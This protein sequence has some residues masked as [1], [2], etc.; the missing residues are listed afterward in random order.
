MAKTSRLVKSIYRLILPVVILVVLAVVAASVFLVHTVSVP[1]Q[2]AYLV[3][4]EKYGQFSTRGARVTDES[5]AN[6]D[7]TKSRGWLLKGAE[8]LPA[9]VFLH[10]YGADRSHVLDLAVK[11]NEAT[12]FTVLMPDERGH[13]VN[14][15]SAQS[16]FGGCEADDALA[17]VEFLRSLKTETGANLIGQNIGFYGVEMGAMSALNAAAKDANVKA[18][19]LDS[20][21]LSSDDVLESAIEKRFPFA[22]SVT[23]KIANLTTPIYFYNGCYRRDAACDLA[24]SV[25][26]RQILLLAGSAAPEL[27]DS[28]QKLDRCF[29]GDTEVETKTDLNPSGYNLMTASLEQATA[30]DQRVIEFFKNALSPQE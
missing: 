29:P 11:L 7:G 14:P 18:V 30:Y 19:A 13:G 16:S 5:W 22:S 4:P 20:V 1:P 8:N 27:Q 21:P 23:A 17:A 26:N 2:T 24:K 28:T 10:R 9:V 15:P 25:N 12:N 6:R 3:T